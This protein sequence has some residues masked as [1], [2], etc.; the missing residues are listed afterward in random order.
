MIQAKIIT[1]DRVEKVVGEYLRGSYL[2]RVPRKRKK[3][4]R[5]ILVY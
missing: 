3:E 5:I 4:D 1:S 2:L